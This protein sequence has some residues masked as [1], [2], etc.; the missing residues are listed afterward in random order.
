[1]ERTFIKI[2]LDALNDNI[3][4]VLNK[5]NGKAKL[6]TVVK[7]DA[8][9]HGAVQIARELEDKCDFFG[10][11]CIE[12]AMELLHADITVP[13]LILGYV[14]PQVY[15]TV[16][17]SNIRIPVFS[18]EVAKALSAE[19]VRQNKTALFHFAVDTGM[20]RIG[21]QVTEESADICRE[22]CA[23]PNIEAE[24]IFSHFATAD[25]ADLSKTLTQKRLFD[26]FLEMLKKRNINIPIKHINNSAGIINFDDM[27]DMVRCGIITYGMYPSDEVDK[28][29]IKL[30]PVMSWQS[31][32]SHI[33]ILDAGREIS[34]GGTY[35]TDSES[36]IATVPVG[37][38]DGYPR[39]LSNNSKVIINGQ[40]A[41]VVGRIC[42]D[43][44]MVDITN[45]DGAQ[46][47]TPVTLIGKNGDA[48]ITMEDF[49]KNA[50]TFNYEQAC[51][52]S[53]RVTRVYTK[54]GIET[55]KVNYL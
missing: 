4:A 17:E 48:E 33:K 25:E 29:S 16:V 49:C 38:A 6:L 30:K 1:M 21:F 52:M 55:E 44:F 24:G 34:Y 46:I 32:I 51:R 41:P 26:S 22:I 27:L 3:D 15:K 9:G 7:A 5:I 50:N 54:N 31:I 18:L 12:E 39:C 11:A 14:S 8:Y 40:Y 28:S 2:D 42:M 53:R 10:V 36:V 47:E 45:I 23:L 43:Q 20:S 35:I 19:A 13:I 37:Y